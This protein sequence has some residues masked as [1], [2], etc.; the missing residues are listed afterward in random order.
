LDASEE[1]KKVLR[2]PSHGR[3]RRFD[4]CIAHHLE[5]PPSNERED[6]F[7]KPSFGCLSENAR[8]RPVG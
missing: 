1:A 4:P 3:G 2:F 7:A 8:V 6:L 5:R